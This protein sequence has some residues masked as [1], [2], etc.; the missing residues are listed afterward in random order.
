MKANRRFLTVS[1]C[2]L[3]RRFSQYF[4]I[5]TESNGGG[6]VIKEIKEGSRRDKIRKKEIRKKEAR[7][8]FVNGYPM[9]FLNVL[10]NTTRYQINY[11]SALHHNVKLSNYFIKIKKVYIWMLDVFIL[12]DKI[13]LI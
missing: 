7:R 11:Q 9:T 3:L 12:L 1:I 2:N 13:I 6:S 4:N 8:A 5:I 10:R